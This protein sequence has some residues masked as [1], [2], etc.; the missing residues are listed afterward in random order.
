MSS[1]IPRHPACRPD[2]PSSSSP[3]EEVDARD[4]AEFIAGQDPLQAA[5]AGWMVRRQD[6]L[7]PQ[8][9]VE[10][11]E[12]L[13]MDPTHASV[14]EQM[15]GVWGRMHELPEEG[16]DS[17]KAGL[18]Q[19]Q[20]AAPPSSAEVPAAAARE[21]RRAHNH[22]LPPFPGRR[23]WLLGLGRLVPQAAT[24]A[25]AFGVVGGGWYGWNTWQR[26]P[27]FEQS[28]GTARGKQKEVK[29]PDG[30]TLWLDTATRIEVTLYRQRREV[31]LAEGQVL[32]AVQSNPEQPFDVLAGDARVTVVGTR[33]SVRRTRSG[34]GDDGG[35]SVMVEEGRVRVTSQSAAH[36]LAGTGTGAGGA[37]ELGA[38]QSI[39]A[40]LAGGLGPVGRNV[41]PATWREGRVSF[42]S[43]PLAQAL[44]EF[45]R[46]G[47][48]GLVIRDPSVG[49]L[50]VNGSFDVRQV[51][52]FTKALPQ[53]L[54]VRL[55]P[56]GDRTEI[57]TAAG[58]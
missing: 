44:A 16:I 21:P 22:P 26:Q 4:H 14:L 30:S 48:T 6:G 5:A 32:F 27:I 56:R 40:E 50:K 49:A 58:G 11:R 7:T 17:L 43:T 12:W 34:L 31:R 36:E 52:A 33:F 51:S 54:P 28:F 9:E 41:A 37:I 18:P 29:L 47:D 19:G 45:E 39:T 38:G 35:V 42:S 57:V 20:V 25:L 1:S 46:Y 24:A 13:A 23:S 3:Q 55:R 2:Q 53:V 8:E 10:F 15:E